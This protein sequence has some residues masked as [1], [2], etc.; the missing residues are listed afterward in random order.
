MVNGREKLAGAVLV[1]T[2]AAGILT[3]IL[4]QEETGRPLPAAVNDTV[5]DSSGRSR[6]GYI[7]LDINTATPEELTALPSIGPAK[8]G[9]I[10]AWR[11]ENGP[12]ERVDDLVSVKGI[13]KKTVA[14][15]E[16]YVCAGGNDSLTSE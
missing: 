2:V 15:I 12:F 8:A 9:A 14:V 3:G 11:E 6:R 1:I 7:R 16:K 13:G 5:S 4:R 10:V